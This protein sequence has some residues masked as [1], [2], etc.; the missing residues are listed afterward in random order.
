MEMYAAGPAWL[1]YFSLK[2]NS[3]N[4]HILFRFFLVLCIV[5]LDYS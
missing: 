2:A 5:L 3:P 4:P 1:T